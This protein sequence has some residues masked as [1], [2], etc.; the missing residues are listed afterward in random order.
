[1]NKAHFSITRGVHIAALLL[2]L[3]GLASAQQASPAAVQPTEP[4]QGAISPADVAPTGN[5]RLILSAADLAPPRPRDPTELLSLLANY[6]LQDLRPPADVPAQFGVM[7]T[8]ADRVVTLDLAQHSV[9]APDFRAFVELGNGDRV[10]FDPGPDR[11]YRGTVVEVP[12]SVVTATL[13]PGGRLTARIDLREGGLWHVESVSIAGQTMH[14]VFRDSDKA[15]L[16]KNWCGVHDSGQAS[17]SGSQPGGYQPRTAVFKAVIHVVG[18]YEWY[19][20]WGS[21]WLTEI[22]GIINDDNA[23]YDGQTGICYSINDA[24]TYTSDSDP[25]TND[26]A[27]N[28]L[29][30]LKSYYNDNYPWNSSFRTVAQLFSGKDLDGSTVGLGY[31]GGIQTCGPGGWTDHTQAYS[32]IE[33]ILLRSRRVEVSAHELGHNWSCPHC[34]GDSTC[35]IMQSTVTVYPGSG[36]TTF[37]STSANQIIA[38]RND[39]SACGRACDFSGTNALC[40]GYCDHWNAYNASR[41]APIGSTLRIY[42]SGRVVGGGSWNEQ[43][44]WT[45]P[46]TLTAPAGPV[47]IGR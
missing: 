31:V 38:R 5:D 17:P 1:M 34:D 40:A 41:L 6:T 33:G 25:Y 16:P 3:C 45:R 29:A 26:N 11:T 35:G 10:E 43:F 7:L 8:L 44:S 12:G 24:R 47:L 20:D 19:G 42:P 21:D 46:M 30:T 15:P 23:I 39:I 9:R 18:D 14:A 32:L 2:G 4:A 13:F 37:G 27:D 28:I 22:S 36:R